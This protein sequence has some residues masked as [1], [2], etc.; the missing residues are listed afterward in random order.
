MPRWLTSLLGG[1]GIAV[2]VFAVE[3][4]VERATGWDL[5]WEA[6]YVTGALMSSW[7]SRGAIPWQRADRMRRAVAD[8]DVVVARMEQLNNDGGKA[9]A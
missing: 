6:G 8:L 9:G 2:A 5:T 7:L 1:A 3:V 4:V